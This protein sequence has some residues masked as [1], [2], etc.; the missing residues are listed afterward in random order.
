M[1]NMI[2]IENVNEK[3]TMSSNF[4]HLVA[5]DYPK[6]SHKCNFKLKVPHHI[7]NQPWQWMKFFG[8]VIRFATY[9]FNFMA[10]SCLLQVTVLWHLSRAIKLFLITCV[11]YNYKRVANLV[12]DFQIYSSD[13]HLM[14]LKL[15]LSS[16]NSLVVL[17][18]CYLNLVA[19]RFA[20][21]EFHKIIFKVSLI[22]LIAS[23][24][25]LL[26]PLLTNHQVN[27]WRNVL[28]SAFSNLHF[29]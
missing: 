15:A 4:D 16:D 6:C 24:Q 2:F 11:Y 14:V 21:L 9:T 12:I 18:F 19:T 23:S 5:C 25:G 8:L 27:L 10:M 28:D 20:Y 17:K 7:K 29:P 3:W 13:I 26:N 1:I 22:M